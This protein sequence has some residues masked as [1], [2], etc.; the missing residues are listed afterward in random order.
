VN[1]QTGLVSLLQTSWKRFEILVAE[2][3]R[4]Q[5]YAVEYS[6]GRGADG[7]VDLI[8]R[9]DRRTSLVQCK[10]WRT[11]SVGGSVI[12]KVFGLLTAEKAH[13]AIFVTSGNFTRDA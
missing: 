12:R 8:I 10:Q 7:G 2:A 13:E 4:R 1:R 3:Y 5:G 11:S 6:L 9:R